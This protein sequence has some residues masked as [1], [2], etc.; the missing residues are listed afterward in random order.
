MK[1]QIMMVSALTIASQLSALLKLWFTARLFGVGPELDGYNL[2]IVLPTLIAGV[3]AGVLQTGLFPVRARLRVAENESALFAFEHSV[4][5]GMAAI[6]VLL[7]ILL[8]L[9]SPIA[10]NHLG[11]SAPDSVRRSLAFAFPFATV[12]VVLNIVGDCCGYLLAA[13]GRFAVAAGAPVA[14]GL[15][16]ALLLATWPEGRLLNL[17]GGTVL[18]VALQVSICLWGLKSTGF[19]ALGPLPD[20]KT[21]RRHCFEI[22]SLGGW[23]LPGVVFSNLAVSLPQVW[24]ARYGEGAVSAF[25]Y[26]YRLHTSALQLLVIASSTVLIA[27]FSDLVAQGD[28]AAIRRILTKAG[29]VS[30]TI[31]VFGLLSVWVIAPTLLKWLFGQRY[32]SASVSRV[33]THWFLL[34]TGI[35]FVMLGNVFAKLFQA[36]KKPFMLSVLAFS[37]FIFLFSMSK[38]LESIN[39]EYSISISIAI[40]GLFSFVIAFIYDRNHSKES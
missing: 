2:A 17:I 1:K 21:A 35:P 15:L 4:L 7:T 10:V 32:S 16:G 23:I 14:S 9:G 33:T 13:R 40:G 34:T 19:S 37:N 12:L 11:L 8:L 29:L 30:V 6:G 25:G 24:V 38:L 5:L 20:W 31:G 39:H 28:T 3:V 36:Q 27:H 18:G 22:L 26:A